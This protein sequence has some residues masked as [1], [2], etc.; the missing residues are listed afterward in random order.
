MPTQTKHIVAVDVKTG[1]KGDVAKEMRRAA[2]SVDAL[3]VKTQRATTKMG[4]SFQAVATKVQMLRRQLQK[5]VIGRAGG[6]ARGAL[7]MAGVFGIGAMIEQTRELEMRFS[8]FGAT[9]G[10]SI[11]NMRKSMDG[12]RKMVLE[13]SNAFGVSQGEVLGYAERIQEATG[14]TDLAIGTMKQIG[15][16]AMATGA[17]M[18]SLGGVVEKLS[19]KL[20]ISKDQFFETMDVFAAQGDKG[21]FELKNLADNF[22][23]VLGLSSSFNAKGISGARQMGALMQ[24]SMRGNASAA[25]AETSATRLL[26]FVARGRDSGKIQKYLGVS[27]L[28]AT[29]E[30]KQI[31][32]IIPE[33]AARIA[34][35]QSTGE[36]INVSKGRKAK[37]VGVGA[38]MQE[39]FG[40][41]GVK[42]MRVF[43]DEALRGPQGGQAGFRELL[44]AGGSGELLNRKAKFISETPAMKLN[45]ALTK[46]NNAVQSKMLPM[47]VKLADK[48]GQL[49]PVVQ[50]VMEHFMTLAK[51][52]AAIKIG[53]FINKATA[54]GI[55][56]P[57]GPAALTSSPAVASRAA[58]VAAP[59]ITRQNGSG[60]TAG[61]GHW[62][63]TGRSGGMTWVPASQAGMTGGLSPVFRER[64]PSGIA[65]FGSAVSGGYRSFA[66]SHVGRN[67]GRYGMGGAIAGS[68]I[69]GGAFGGGKLETGMDSAA[70]IAMMAG[71]PAGLV[72]GG[73][74]FAAKGIFNVAKAEI[75]SES[76]DFSG[77][78]R[79]Q[80]ILESGATLEERASRKG[81]GPE[82]KTSFAER[83]NRIK[84]ALASGDPAKIAAAK[85]ELAASIQSQERLFEGPGG[86]GAKKIFKSSKKA[87][88]EQK[89][90]FDAERD[91]ASASPF[92]ADIDTLEAGPGKSINE[93]TNQLIANQQM[94]AK[95]I[96]AL[97]NLEIRAVV[98]PNKP[99]ERVAGRQPATA[100]AGSQ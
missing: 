16:V 91:F 89:A 84:A 22:T 7:G 59:A 87:L 75:N 60:G 98:V 3:A 40:E 93:N 65:R 57:A 17:D 54:A 1:S 100:G 11:S 10:G 86:E 18:G 21:S 53:Q 47:L 41:M 50:L 78:G 73:A 71:G 82:S 24:M 46:I 14:N 31:K 49:V 45:K 33:I 92:L 32:E 62:E 13:T 4:R 94:M 79:E 63:R 2:Q 23:K 80:S 88:L 76:I 39:L 68:L 48:M 34:Q 69:P 43:V 56:S 66:N 52:F 12:A 36:K 26:S 90:D 6:M 38:V 51:L 74:Y 97:K 96:S 72:A 77:L 37:M 15:K 28:T 29:G 95:L 61:V 64:G 55:T 27:G 85:S 99:A 58:A 19:T 70:A 67:A 35:L 30:K 42:T 25:E 9:A 8:R 5:G 81:I 44:S 83:Q 20:G